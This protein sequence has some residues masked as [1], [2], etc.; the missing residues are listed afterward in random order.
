MSVFEKIEKLPEDVKEFFHSNEVRLAME[1]ACFLYDIA[2]ED[3]E[4]L[5]KPVGN[6]F[7]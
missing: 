5:A 4:E 3:I 6:I 7:F 1:Q 2:E